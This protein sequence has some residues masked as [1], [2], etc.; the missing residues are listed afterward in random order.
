MKTIIFI[1]LKVFEIAL[2]PI[3]YGILCF[4]WFYA[5]LPV[6]NGERSDVSIL[7]PLCFLGGIL[8]FISAF[9]LFIIIYNIAIFIPVWISKNKKWSNDIIEWVKRKI[10]NKL[11]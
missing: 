4:I 10:T 3:I 11:R 1:L 5:T 6:V 2:I 8:P 9:I 7:H